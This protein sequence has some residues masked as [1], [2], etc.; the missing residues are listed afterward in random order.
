MILVTGSAGYFGSLLVPELL[1][2]ALDVRNEDAF[3]FRSPLNVY[4]PAGTH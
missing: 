2:R 4:P 3:W 1:G